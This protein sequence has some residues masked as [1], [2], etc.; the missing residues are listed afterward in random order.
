M[1]KVITS[2]ILL[3]ALMSFG[4]QAQK[5]SV[6]AYLGEYACISHGTA[7]LS[8]KQSGTGIVMHFCKDMITNSCQDVQLHAKLGA[9][10]QLLAAGGD[11]GNPINGMKVAVSHQGTQPILSFSFPDG[12]EMEFMRLE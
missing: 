3:F 2:L 8:L 4:L 12:L 10:S 7:T 6:K 5:T 9:G 11:A 1:K